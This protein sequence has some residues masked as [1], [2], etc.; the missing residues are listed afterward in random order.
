MHDIARCRA[1]TQ[2]T[3]SGREQETVT[4]STFPLRAIHQNFLDIRHRGRVAVQDYMMHRPPSGMIIARML[5]NNTI[6]LYIRV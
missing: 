3:R 6:R 1:C 4:G 5:I 2:V